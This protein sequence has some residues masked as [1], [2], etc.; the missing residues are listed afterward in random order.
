VCGGEREETGRKLVGQ[1][2]GNLT[3]QQTEGTVTTTV[4][5]RSK[6]QQRTARPRQPLSQTGPAPGAPEPRESPRRSPPPTG[7]QRDVTWYGIPGSVW[8]GGVSPH[9][10]GCAP[11]W[12]PVKINPVLAKPRTVRSFSNTSRPRLSYL[13]LL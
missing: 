1:D 4:Q 3:E 11:S 7:T 13:K 8:P 10:P 9:P 12:S 2:K 6:T 5:I